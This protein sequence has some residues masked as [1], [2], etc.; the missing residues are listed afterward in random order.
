MLKPKIIFPKQERLESP[1]QLEDCKRR[2][3]ELKRREITFTSIDDNQ[4]N[5]RIR[6]IKSVKFPMIAYEIHGTLRRWGGTGT[7]I[8]NYRLQRLTVRTD[9]WVVLFV[10]MSLLASA[11]LTLPTIL[12][13]TNSTL[14]VAMILIIVLV[15]SL[16]PLITWIQQTRALD[17]E[18][19]IQHHHNT[20]MSALGID[21]HSQ[22]L[23]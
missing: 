9:T 2:L 18:P 3:R 5:F 15:M 12:C 13:G 7:L 23:T 19:E 22:D 17:V 10:V 1:Y 11:L 4:V 8:D 6:R 21:K 14:W 16:L 20:I